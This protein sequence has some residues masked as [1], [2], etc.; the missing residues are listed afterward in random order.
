M[1]R[2]RAIGLA[3][4]LPATVAGVAIWPVLL[5]CSV[6]PILGLFTL[7][8]LFSVSC[9]LLYGVTW[10]LHAYLASSE[11]PLPFSPIRCGKISLHAL[12][13]A[14][15][16]VAANGL[17]LVIDAQV[18]K[19]L[20]LGSSESKAAKIIHE[21]IPYGNQGQNSIPGGAALVFDIEVKTVN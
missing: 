11:S 10:S 21:N 14:K 12:R 18:R 15:D 16:F 6:L 19:L 5:V 9:F 2:S 17:N 1:V 8:I 20:L 3:V 13:I 4:L 7:P